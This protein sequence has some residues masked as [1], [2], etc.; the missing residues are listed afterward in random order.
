[1]TEDIKDRKKGEGFRIFGI[2]LPSL[3]SLVFKL[4]GTFLKFKREAKKAGCAFRKELL[5][6]GINTTTAEELTEIY[7][8]PSDIRQYMRY[9]R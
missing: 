7:L 1:M 3:P 5:K 6:Q 2:L 4:G 9:F 8:E